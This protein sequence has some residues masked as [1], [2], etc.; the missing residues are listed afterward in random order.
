MSAKSVVTIRGEKK[1]SEEPFHLGILIIYKSGML[2]VS[3]RYNAAD[4]LTV[5]IN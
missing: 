1:K 3:L 5:Q 2:T 4:S